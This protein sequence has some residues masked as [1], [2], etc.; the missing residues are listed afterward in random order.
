[1]AGPDEGAR[2]FLESRPDLVDEVLVEGDPVDL[3]T[4][5]DLAAWDTRIRPDVP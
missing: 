4:P 5:E 1:M 3:D 2:R